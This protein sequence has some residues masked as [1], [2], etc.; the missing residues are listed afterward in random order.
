MTFQDLLHALLRIFFKDIRKEE[1]GPSYAGSSS[2]MDFLLH[3]EEIVIEVKMTREGL[4]Q[5][6]LV[7]QLLIDIARYE[8]PTNRRKSIC[9][10][11]SGVNPG[12]K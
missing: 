12:G 4:K 2:R 5:K 9:L 7:D 11:E 8:T 6:E 1:W 3:Q 10:K